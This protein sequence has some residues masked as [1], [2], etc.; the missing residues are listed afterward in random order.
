M[1]RSEVIQKLL[2]AYIFQEGV[3]ADLS[4]INKA[5][6]V[7]ESFKHEESSFKV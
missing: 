7:I 1:K 5:I 2:D 3:R 6:K 4:V